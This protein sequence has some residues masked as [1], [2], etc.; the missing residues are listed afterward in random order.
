MILDVITGILLWA[1]AALTGYVIAAIH[2]NGHRNRPS[3]WQRWQAWRWDV[4]LAAR[5]QAISTLNSG[6]WLPRTPGLDE[7]DPEPWWT[8]QQE[9]LADTGAFA[10]VGA[11]APWHRQT[12]LGLAATVPAARRDPDPHLED[13]FWGKWDPWQ[14]GA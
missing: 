13:T 5:A 8:H 6:E 9:R 14:V 3:L 1:A 7:P 10:A 12:R 4:W 2:A 11:E